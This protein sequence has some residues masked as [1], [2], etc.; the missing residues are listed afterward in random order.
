MV[1]KNFMCICFAPCPK[2]SYVEILLIKKKQ[3]M[4]IV[5]NKF[6]DIRMYLNRNVLLSRRVVIIKFYVVFIENLFPLQTTSNSIFN[7][8]IIK[9]ST[10]SHFSHYLQL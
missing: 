2:S 5:I 4:M 8:L 3:E 7:T 9:N 10:K 6:K 1:L